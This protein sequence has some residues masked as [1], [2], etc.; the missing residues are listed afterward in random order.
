MASLLARAL[1]KFT[2]PAEILTAHGGE[3]A[4]AFIRQRVPDVLLTDLKMAGMNG[5]ELIEKL[6][7]SAGRQP[8]YII[9]VT[10]HDGPDVF[11]TARRL[12]VNDCLLKPV[13]PEKF[14]EIVG[15][16]LTSLSTPRP[17]SGAPPSPRP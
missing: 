5:L 8:G 11:A 14:R 4:L 6:R 15:R 13:Q 12:N 16:A 1:G 17:P 10:A 7:A 9:L 2:V 3:E